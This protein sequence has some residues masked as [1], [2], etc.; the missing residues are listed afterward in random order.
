MAGL[1]KNFGLFSFA[2]EIKKKKKF[3]VKNA[4]VVELL[5]SEVLCFLGPNSKCE[6]GEKVFWS[7]KTVFTPEEV[8]KRWIV[9]QVCGRVSCL[10]PIIIIIILGFSVKG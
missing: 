4:F 6:G 5:C 3:A 7:R 2:A 10:F 8:G 1:K 9:D